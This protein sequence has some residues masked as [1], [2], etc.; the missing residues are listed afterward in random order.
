MIMHLC[1]LKSFFC[2]A[3]MHV[4]YSE[5]LSLDQQLD[6]IVFETSVVRGKL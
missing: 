4:R 1:K 5:G 6:G 3:R 2:A